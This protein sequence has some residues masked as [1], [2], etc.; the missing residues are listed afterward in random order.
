MGPC[1]TTVPA[2]P[3]PPRVRSMRDPAARAT[4]SDV[5]ATKSKSP[6][7]RGGF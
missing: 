1:E 4:P 2:D 6:R 7:E 3:P 5:V